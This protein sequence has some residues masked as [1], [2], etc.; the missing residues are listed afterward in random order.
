MGPAIIHVIR[1]A[2]GYHQLP[3]DHPHVNIHDPSLTSKGIEQ[4]QHFCAQFPY[5][6]QTTHLYASPM[7]RT[8]QTAGIA[9]EPELARGL[10][11]IALPDA[12][13]ATDALS[14]TG[15]DVTVLREEF[16]DAVSYEHVVGPWYEK[17]GR[18]ATDLH[19]LFERAKRLRFSLKNQTE[20]GSQIVLVT[21]GLFA[22]FITGHIDEQ[23]AQTGIVPRAAKK[24][25]V[26]VL[27]I[28]IS[29]MVGEYWQNVMWRSFVFENT[30]DK[31]PGLIETEESIQRARA[32][33]AAEL[34]G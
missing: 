15:S 8:L 12:Q 28:L 4:S 13:E 32:G 34:I 25:C 24:L 22:H 11:I 33:E 1:H 5:H 3:R 20:E 14:D 18:N 30:D 17:T 21:H 2:E 6:S 26:L 7:R 23:G 16:G 19:S 9:F 27:L 31:H 29:F 10:K